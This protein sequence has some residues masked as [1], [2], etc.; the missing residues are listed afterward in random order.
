[1]RM[2]Q[3]RRLSVGQ[4]ANWG[5]GGGGVVRNPGDFLLLIQRD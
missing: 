2:V 1:M 5:R 3:T 4:T